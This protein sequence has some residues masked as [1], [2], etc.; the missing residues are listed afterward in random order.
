MQRPP[1]RSHRMFPKFR[2]RIRL[3]RSLKRFTMPL[4]TSMRAII[5]R[6]TWKKFFPQK[7]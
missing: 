1:T 7:R 2:L 5:F 6:E 4:S 3:F